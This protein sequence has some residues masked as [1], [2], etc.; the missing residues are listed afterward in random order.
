MFSTLF[1]ACCCSSLGEMYDSQAC[2]CVCGGELGGA[3]GGL[4]TDEEGGG[5]KQAEPPA[6]QRSAEILTGLKK[7]GGRRRRKK[8]N[9]S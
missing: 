9:C 2:E 6:L 7:M 3:L 1:A 5:D 8:M 4:E